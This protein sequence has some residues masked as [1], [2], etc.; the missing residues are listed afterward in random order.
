VP[1]SSVPP[2]PLPI[3]PQYVAASLE[4]RIGVQSPGETSRGGIT[5]LSRGTM[6]FPEESASAPGNGPASVSPPW[7]SSGDPPQPTAAVNAASASAMQTKD[8]RFLAG[9]TIVLFSSIIMSVCEKGQFRP[10]GKD[11][12]GLHWR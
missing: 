8:K 11:P 5:L 10:N 4:Q 7:K 6:T 2:Q 12:T 3:I 9:L 1:Q